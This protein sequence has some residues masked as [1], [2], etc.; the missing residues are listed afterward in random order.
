MENIF[1]R[2][3]ADFLDLYVCVIGYCIYMVYLYK[4]YLYKYISNYTY[5]LFVCHTALQTWPENYHKNGKYYE[6]KKKK[7]AKPTAFS[8]VSYIPT[9]AE[10]IRSYNYYFWRRFFFYSTVNCFN[11][12]VYIIP[13][14]VSIIHENWS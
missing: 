2:V 11:L 9:R 4:V 8:V 10:A 14:S 5:I 13:R 6:T 1:Q 7:E 3:P 12:C